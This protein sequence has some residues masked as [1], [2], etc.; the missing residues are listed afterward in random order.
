MLLLKALWVGESVWVWTHCWGLGIATQIIQT[1]ISV[2]QG[3]FIECRTPRLIDQG[4][5]LDSGAAWYHELRSYRAFKPKFHKHCT[6]LLYHSG[7]RD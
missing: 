7:F 1:P 4:Y 6:K 5:R 2:K 3:W